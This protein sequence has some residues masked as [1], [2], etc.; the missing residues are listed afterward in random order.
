MDVLKDGSVYY[1]SNS[2]GNAVVSAEIIQDSLLPGK[3]TR[4][5]TFKLLLPK[6]LLAELNTHRVFSRNA[7]STR[8]IPIKKTIEQLQNGHYFEP[9]HWGKNKKGMSAEVEMNTP[10]VMQK[11]FG[12]KKLPK[13]EVWN[14]LVNMMAYAAECYSEAGYHKQIVGRLLDSFTLASVIL[15]STE[16]DN[17]FNLRI[18][19]DAQPEMASLAFAMKSAMDDSAPVETPCHIPML[20]AELEKQEL[21]Q[22]IRSAVASCARVSYI[23]HGSENIDTKKDNELFNMLRSNGHWSPFEHVAFEREKSKELLKELPEGNFSGNFRDWI[24]LRQ[25]MH[26]L[27]DEG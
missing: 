13:E 26:L 11:M 6:V 8:A 18:S 16:W 2:F 7:S 25:I 17:F 21:A 12:G 14:K 3:G 10:I 5:T 15:S 23:N 27:K 4:L 1:K 20:S 9:L 19:K 24:Q 22:Q